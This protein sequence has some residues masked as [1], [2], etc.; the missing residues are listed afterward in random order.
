[1]NQQTPSSMFEEAYAA[2]INPNPGKE[3][4]AALIAARNKAIMR[5]IAEKPATSADIA[6]MLHRSP[7]E[8]A[9]SLRILR[10]HNWGHTQSGNGG[11]TWHI[12]PP[13]KD[14]ETRLL[15]E[16]AKGYKTSHELA[17]ALAMDTNELKRITQLMSR[18]HL[19]HA[20]ERGIRAKWVAG[21]KPTEGV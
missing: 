15:A 20:T 10:K 3:T 18:R 4:Q 6:K 16:L 21:P 13:R 8:A 19:I 9:R 2:M 1:M 11:I 5:F 17:A 14:D 7:E 12:G